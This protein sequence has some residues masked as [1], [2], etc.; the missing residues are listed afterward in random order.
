MIVLKKNAKNFTDKKPKKYYFVTFEFFK[1]SM[2]SFFIL[3][4]CEKNFEF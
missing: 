3:F 1:F 2:T 4:T